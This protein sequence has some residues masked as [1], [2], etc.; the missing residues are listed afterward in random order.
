[1]NTPVLPLKA[2]LS[3]LEIEYALAAHNHNGQR[4]NSRI[5]QALFLDG[6]KAEQPWLPAVE[7]GCFVGNGARIYWDAGAHPEYAA[8]ECAGH[9]RELVA[10]IHAGHAIMSRIGRRM[11]RDRS[12]AQVRIWRGN[13]DYLTGETWGCHEN[14][15]TRHSTNLLAADLLP[16]LVSR[17]IYGGAG[18]FS[19]KTPGRFSLSPRLEQFVLGQSIQTTENR[20]I[21]NTRDQSHTDC[22]N[23]VHLIC[24]DNLISQ[25][26]DML[27]IG[28]TRL[29]VALADRRLN[30]PNRLTFAD[31]VE[32]L[33]TFCGDPTCTKRV[34]TNRGMLSAIDI[35]RLCI[36]NI[37]SH[38]ND[39]PDWCTE[40][41][42]LCTSVLNELEQDPRQL[43]GRLDWPTKFMLFE[44]NAK[45]SR[46]ELMMQD[47]ILS[48][49]A[50]PLLAELYAQHG[51]NTVSAPQISF[52]IENAPG[53]TRA[54]IRGRVVKQLSGQRKTFCWWSGVETPER[55][56]DLREPFETQEKWQ[57]ISRID[58]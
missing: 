49:L 13:V 14:Y 44:A 6:L 42:D 41:A 9:P 39:L 5:T 10:Q 17:V 35:Q 20:G 26:A 33:H 46:E 21:I 50:N 2:I 28:M 12:V 25:F 38:T 23:R 29:V 24:R 48:D 3:S 19:L 57:A 40:I 22:Y 27:S 36:E 43:F 54:K 16:H 52:S 7:G 8:P 37:V 1:M 55:Q 15:L 51:G 45:R 58:R 53:S 4:L 47:V 18:G 30:T 31:E 34:L 32:A 11:E 56:L